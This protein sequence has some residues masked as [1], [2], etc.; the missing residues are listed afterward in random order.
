[1]GP[2]LDSRIKPPDVG[3]SMLQTEYEVEVVEHNSS[4]E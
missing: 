4:I 2:T 1:M 3:I